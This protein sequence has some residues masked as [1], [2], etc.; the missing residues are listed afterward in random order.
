MCFI[1]YCLLV[2]KFIHPDEMAKP[3]GFRLRQRLMV[4]I[5]H[6]DNATL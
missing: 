4:S 2:G 6:H 5:I 3:T 1:V